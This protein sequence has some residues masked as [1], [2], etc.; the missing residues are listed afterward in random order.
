MQ[1]GP[2][3]TQDK[4]SE[5]SKETSKTYT[6]TDVVEIQRKADSD[7]RA[8]IGRA[9]AAAEKA[10]KIA[11]DTLAKL[12]KEQDRAYEEDRE[13]YRDDATKLSSLEA[14]RRD[15]DAQAK[16]EEAEDKLREANEK[17]EEADRANKE[18]TSRDNVHKVAERTGVDLEQL[19]RFAKLTDGSEEA[20][21]AEAKML[22]KVSEPKAPLLADTGKGTGAVKLTPEMVKNMSSSEKWD[23]RDEINQIPLGASFK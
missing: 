21:E 18:S 23:R 9:T 11:N 13:R 17:T 3:N 22:P 1:D 15:R 12:K 8:A 19:S 20:I 6:E 14:G 4:S 2:E 16:L 10:T 5:E 7:A